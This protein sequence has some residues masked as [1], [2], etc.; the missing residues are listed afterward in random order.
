MRQQFYQMYQSRLLNR[1]TVKTQE[2]W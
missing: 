2:M 1:Q